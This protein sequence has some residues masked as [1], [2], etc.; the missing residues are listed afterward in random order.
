MTHAASITTAIQ[1]S[2]SLMVFFLAKSTS[3]AANASRLIPDGTKLTVSGRPRRRTVL[4]GCFG[5]EVEASLA[6]FTL[7]VT[8]AT[9]LKRKDVGG[10][11]VQEFV[12]GRAISD[13]GCVAV[14]SKEC[15]FRVRT[16]NP[17]SV[18][19]GAVGS[20]KPDI[21]ESERT[22]MPVAFKAGWI[23]WEENHVTLEEANQ[24][25]QDHVGYKDVE[26]K[27]R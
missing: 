22:R 23:V 14:E 5:I 7:T 9:I 13:V 3:I 4:I 12:S 6:R 11:V 25:Q 16:G 1:A 10:R 18:E 2:N 24:G 21:L 17:P 27:H 8:V 26:Q 15:E 20:R 19:L